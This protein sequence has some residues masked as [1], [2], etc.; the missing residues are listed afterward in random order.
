[1]TIETCK[2]M[3][4]LAKARNDKELVRFWEKRIIRKGGK[5]EKPAE[6]KSKGKR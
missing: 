3:L 5:L 2:R 1:M 6:I 4:E